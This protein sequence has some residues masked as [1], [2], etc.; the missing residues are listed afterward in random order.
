[1]L[2]P[3]V[4]AD[5]EKTRIARILNTIL[6]SLIAIYTVGALTPLFAGTVQRRVLLCVG[7]VLLLS[8]ALWLMRR[9]HVQIAIAVFLGVFWTTLTSS[10]YT[11]GGVHAP[12]FVAYVL[13]I[14][15]AGL[16]LGRRALILA[17]VVSALSGFGLAYAEIHGWLPLHLTVHTPA[18]LARTY[19]VIFLALAVLLELTL[20]NIRESLERAHHEIQQ[21]TATEQTL[22]QSEER[23][24]I[25]AHNFPDAMVVLFDRE[26]R[27]TLVDGELLETLG[28]NR[29]SLEGKTIWESLPADLCQIIEPLYRAALAEETS[30]ADVPIGDRTCCF[31]TSP[32]HDEAGQVIFGMVMAQDITERKRSEQSLWESEQ[33]FRKL[34][35]EGPIG[36]SI[37]S[38]DLNWK[39]VNVALCEMT[40]YTAEELTARSFADITHPDD[41]SV[42]IDLAARLIAGKAPSYTTEKRYITKTGGIIWVNLSV[43]L[44]RDTQGTPLYFL[45]MVENITVRKQTEQA[46]RDSEARFRALIE[47][48][49]DIITILDKDAKI[50]YLS[51]SIQ[52]LQGYR[53]EEVIATNIFGYLHPADVDDC[54]KIMSRLLAHQGET[55]TFE[56]RFRHKDGSWRYLE[57]SICNLLG[58]P[59]IDGII[60]S[61]HDVTERKRA[62]GQTERQ[63]QRLQALRTIDLAI[64]GSFDL[65]VTLNVVLDQV[66]SLLGVDAAN[67]LMV[68]PHSHTLEYVA[69]RGIGENLHGAPSVRLGEGLVGRAALERR[70]VMASDLIDVDDSIEAIDL[71]TDCQ[72]HGYYAVP[73]IAKGRANGVLEVFCKASFIADGEWLEFLEALAGQA[74][75]AVDNA[76]L[77]DSLQQSNT[78]LVLAYDATI[79][80]WSRALDLRDKETEGH[81]QRV[82]VM[83]VR[84]AREM[85]ISEEDLVHIRRGALLHDIGKM[86]VPDGI[87]HKPDKLTEE[88]WKKMQ[89]HT[90]FAYEMLSPIRFLRLAIDIPYC[91]HEKWDGTGYPRGLKGDV[92]PLPARIFAIVDVWD[93]LRSDRVYR[94]ALPENEV[95][96]YIRAQSG[97]HFDPAVVEAFL[98]MLAHTQSC[99][100]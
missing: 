97:K 75:I 38:L 9:G 11:G 83:A 24:R 98:A 3:P 84:L 35:E 59:G 33:R 68:N 23:Y 15:S 53:P 96:D 85:G 91:H 58:Y 4:F 63:L 47:N 48:G 40:G 41:Q 64:S 29:E 14:A 93:A 22:R 1:M 90:T 32:V 81:T 54:R 57:N 8:Y 82:T 88:E 56:C 27:F 61:A 26:L 80:G 42:G 39:H 17:V 92:I 73:L 49:S 25:L 28:Y 2:A 72:P 89:A 95:R 30:I 44:I 20:R 65:R 74:A 52:R 76:S 55:L 34:F 69:Q 71:L 99:L 19:A 94:K 43:A 13:V 79:E 45:S 67:I 50:R 31:H 100:T 87:L 51:P 21:R 16:L 46:M 78:E 86:G 10:A 36:V 70:V 6:L 77:F 12:A 60:G 7:T 37:V 5:A 18:T 62:E 66:T